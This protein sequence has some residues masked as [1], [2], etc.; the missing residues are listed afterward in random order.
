[1]R[2][3]MLPLLLFIVVVLLPACAPPQQDLAA[4]RKTIEEYNAAS[5]KAM[6][7]GSLGD[8]A[9]Y[10]ADDARDLPPNMPAIV[11]KDSVVAN[12]ARSIKSGPK[13]TMVSFTIGE[14]N[15]GGSVAWEI[16]TYEMTADVPSMGSMS[17]VG[18]YVALWKQQ[19][20][21]SWKLHAEIWNSN[22][23]APIPAKKNAK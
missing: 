20:D 17:D 9:M 7:T 14:I 1:M 8:L 10:Y 19:A 21:H 2:S 23:A 11:G 15:A 6:M 12:L 5:S 16:G 3:S 22:L 18:K 4:L 13:I